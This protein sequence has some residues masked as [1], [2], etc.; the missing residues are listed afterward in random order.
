MTYTETLKYYESIARKEHY[1][2]DREFNKGKD[3]ILKGNIHSDT[4]KYFLQCLCIP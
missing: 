4:A 1:T 3:D 2:K